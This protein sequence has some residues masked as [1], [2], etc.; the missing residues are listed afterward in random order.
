MGISSKDRLELVTLRKAY[1]FK[2]Q[3]NGQ[4]QEEDGETGK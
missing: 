2:I 3:E 4:H 1:R